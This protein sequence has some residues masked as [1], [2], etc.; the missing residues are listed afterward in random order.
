MISSNNIASALSVISQMKN[1]NYHPTNSDYQPSSNS[2]A[3]NNPTTPRTKQINVNPTSNVIQKVLQSQAAANNKSKSPNIVQA[4]EKYMQQLFKDTPATG[5]SPTPTNQSVKPGTAN[6]PK[7]EL[8][9]GPCVFD[10]SPINKPKY[11]PT[12]NGQRPSTKQG[13]DNY[14]TPNPKGANNPSTKQTANENYPTPNPK[15]FNNPSIRQTTNENYPTPNPKGVNNPSTKQTANENY[16]TPNPK[17]T[18]KFGFNILGGM[19]QI[20]MYKR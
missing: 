18:N 17:G 10:A 13:F 11:T 7:R 16:P 1:S 3:Y 20:G 5:R 15:G 14:P 2:N 8:N 9:I 19:R 6:Y 4:K 12:N